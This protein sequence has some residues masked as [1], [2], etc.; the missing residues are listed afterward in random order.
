V[1]IGSETSGFIRNVIVKNCV[2][3]S[4]N[5]APIRFKTQPSR[6]G[7]AENICFENI[8]IVSARQAFEFNM[9][10]RMVPPVLPPAKVLPVFRNI[11]LKNINGKVEK[12][13]F[14]HGLKDSPITGVNFVNCNLEARTGLLVQNTTGNNYNGLNTKIVEGEKITER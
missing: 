3:D 8:T 10:W 12:L 7:G 5:W 9:E 6:G 1:A 4:G 11:T 13:G 2:A 14:L